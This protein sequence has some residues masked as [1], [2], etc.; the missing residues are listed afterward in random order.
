MDPVTLHLPPET[1]AALAAAAAAEDVSVGQ[2][3]RRAIDRELRRLSPAKT[4]VRADERL[5]A[6]LRALLADDLAFSR[7]W[8]EL[9]DRL[10]RKGFLLVESGGGLLLRRL[11]DGARLCKGSELGYSYARLLERFGAPFPGH[12]HRAVLHRVQAAQARFS[13]SSDG[14]D[15]PAMR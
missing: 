2:I 9:C 11:S 4:P 6:P 14:T 5:V 1:R 8:A 15:R 7:T 10:A 13:P 3:I 12:S